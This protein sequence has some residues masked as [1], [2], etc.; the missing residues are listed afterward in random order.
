MIQADRE[1][2]VSEFI[3]L[4]KID[5][6]TGY[7]EKIS[8]V[9]KAK[10]E[11]LGFKVEE[12]DAKEKTGHES[13]N[14]ICTLEG[15]KEGVEPIFF[16][17]HMDTVVPG[18]DIQPQIEG[19][20]IRS[21]G[22]TILGADDKA[23]IAAIIEM[24]RLL[25]DYDIEHGQIQV[26]LTIG[27]ESGLIGAKALDAS[28]IDAKYGYAVD[29]HG[30]VGGLI[31]ASPTQAKFEITCHGKTAHAGVAP[32]EGISAITL[33][34]KA[35]SKMKL[36]RID[37]DTTANIC[38]FEGGKATNI[39]S[40]EAVV[41]AEA[42][43]LVREKLD[44]QIEQIKEA[45]RQAE[46]EVGGSIDVDVKIMYKGYK[47]DENAQVVKVASQ[48][49]KRIGLEPQLKATGGGSDANVISSYGFPMVN[50]CVGYQ[51]IHTPEE[52]ISINEMMNISALLTGIVIEAAEE[53]TA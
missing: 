39:V 51:N 37:E 31:V 10:F 25:K 4:V 49:A 18:K 48:A 1:R 29:S 12:D 15:T 27:E 9:L 33:A 19:D 50:L 7:E 16:N 8:V 14:L 5:S 42:R 36:G 11:A 26:V 17:S 41:I 30:D 38:R 3:E 46:E 35:I 22:T 6:E 20:T 32:E 44:R 43:S 28:L 47:H 24:V 53:G 23:G 21:D 13:N 34:S 2:L 40:D 45:C 52:E